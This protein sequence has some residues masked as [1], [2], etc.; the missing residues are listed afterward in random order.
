LVK[1]NWKINSISMRITIP[2]YEYSPYVNIITC[3]NHT[4]HEKFFIAGN[5]VAGDKR[6]KDKYLVRKAISSLFE[7]RKPEVL[8]NANS[9]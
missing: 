8:K 1:K 2:K 9:L 3:V 5:A 7:A 6:T 4:K